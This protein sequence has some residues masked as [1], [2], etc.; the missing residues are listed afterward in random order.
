[1]KFAMPRLLVRHSILL[2]VALA[3]LALALISLAGMSASVMVAESVQGSASAINHAGSL[4]RL[5]YRVAGLVAADALSGPLSPRRVEAAIEDFERALG[6]PELQRIVQRDPGGLFAATYR[7]VDS[8]WRQSLRPSLKVMVRAEP[9]TPPE[10]V[11][12]L[13]TNVDR[14]V[15]QLD[16]L[17]FVLEQD[18]EARIEDLREILAGAIIAT[19]VVIIVALFI[20]R[21][22]LLKPLGGLLAATRAIARGDYSARV[23]HV[24][25]DELGRV[26]ATFNLMAG[27]ISRQYQTLEQRVAEKTAELQ[28]SNRSLELLYHAIARLYQTPTEPA[29]YEATLRDIDHVAGLQGS[30]ACIEPRQEGPAT[31]IA[32]TLGPCVERVARGDQACAECRAVSVAGAELRGEQKLLR[33]PLRDREHHYGMLR[34]ALPAGEALEDWQRQLVEALSRH[35]GMALGA[36]RRSEQERLLALQ[37]ERS[38]IA[39]ELHDSL[40]QALSYM[41]IQM[42]LLQRALAD[43][44]RLAEADTILADLRTG[45]N[46]AYR[47]LREL[48]VSF[49]LELS[50]DLGA[51]LRAAVAEYRERGG[52]DIALEIRLSDCSLTPNQEVH[53]LQ[54]VREAL[55]NML[56]HAMARHARVALACDEGG[57]VTIT[58]EDDGVGIDDGPVD[59]RDHHGLS[60]MR[61]RARSLGGEIEITRRGEGGTRISVNFQAVHTLPALAVDAFAEEGSR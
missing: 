20:L 58:V 41:K 44:A 16:T 46:D 26:G 48:L 18:T 43:P 17:V 31:V 1:M 30:F 23:E 5:T 25:Y 13:L 38:V 49:R 35:I 39:R 6:H 60:I 61:E 36:A 11:E 54:I 40:A 10:E 8:S 12:A 7:G 53:V 59:G 29:V 22:S 9:S 45:V 27:E 4:R 42:S 21:R 3:M 28:R 56:R 2:L 14:F 34:L 32:S 51:L 19:L 50:G 24:G 15:D 52:V 57:R 55:S 47:Q 33:F 37:E